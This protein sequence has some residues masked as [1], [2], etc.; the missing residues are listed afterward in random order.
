MH[1]PTQPGTSHSWLIGLLRRVLGLD[2]V[3]EPSLLRIRERLDRYQRLADAAQD[4]AELIQLYEDEAEEH[5]EK[6]KDL[7][8]AVEEYELEAAIDAEERHKLEGQNRWLR[9][10]LEKMRDYDGAYGQDTVDDSAGYPEDFAQLYAEMADLRSEGIILTA[11]EDTLLG[12]GDIDLHGMCLQTAWE[13][14]RTLRDYRRATLQGKA[15]HGLHRYL[16]EP[17][18]GFYS[19]GTKK[20]AASESDTTRAAYGHLRDFKVPKEV[21]PSG[22]VR[23]LAHMKLARIGIVSPRMHFYDDLSRSGKIVIGYIGPHLRTVRTN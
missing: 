15:T 22:T 1:A 16:A 11:D 2:I 18:A 9:Q 21:D 3:D 23:M 14:A 20:Y 12:L 17:P 7:Q 4:Q 6:I 19:V 5:D 10:R 8:A 13:A